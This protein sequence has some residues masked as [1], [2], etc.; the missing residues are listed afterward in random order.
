MTKVCTHGP[1][2]FGHL[3]KTET[4][5]FLYR[6]TLE[7]KSKEFFPKIKKNK[8]IKLTKSTSVLNLHSVSFM[9]FKLSVVAL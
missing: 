1:H 3:E 7:E 4:F 9:C 8:K 2:T 5:T 6:T